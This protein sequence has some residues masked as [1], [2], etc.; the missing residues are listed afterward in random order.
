VLENER[1]ATGASDHGGR[2][3][4]VYVVVLLHPGQEKLLGT[5]G[6]I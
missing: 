6:T 3:S 2:S 5:C 4:C 1:V